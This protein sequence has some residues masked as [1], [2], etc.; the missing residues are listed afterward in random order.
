MSIR[1]LSIS[2]LSELTGK[3]RATITKRLAE[4]KPYKA[5]KT[6]KIYDS[7]I[8]LPMIL[9]I[10]SSSKI[11]KKLLEESLRLESAKADKISLEVERQRGTLVQ[12]ESIAKAV[13]KE[14][15]NTRSGL[16]KIGHTVAAT[17]TNIEERPKLKSLID[18]KVN[19]ALKHLTADERFSEEN[20]ELLNGEDE[21]VESG[22]TSVPD[23]ATDTKTKA[24]TKSR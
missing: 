7:Q 13:A 4:I 9:G 6:S 18:E 11:E 1:Y 14:Y 17:W 2:K 15:T 20:P 21:N 5:T 16:M 24:A 12:T 22:E 10:E 23:S 8:V 19:E 3:D